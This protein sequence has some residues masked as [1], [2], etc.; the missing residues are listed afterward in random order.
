MPA[1][2][3]E[4]EIPAHA[5]DP[6]LLDALSEAVESGAGLPAVARAA[7][8]LLDASVALIDRSSAVLAVAGAS[9]DQEQK[10]LSGGD[11]VTAVEL[12]VADSAVGELRYR[13]RVAPQPAIARM[14]TTLLALELERSRSPEWESEEVASAFVGDVLER[15]VTDRGDIVARGSELGAD[16]DR[17][18][19]VLVLRA[20][21]RAAQTGEWRERVLTL[22][23][24]ALRSLAPG[25]LATME[26]GSEG[27]AAN[28]AVIVPA[29][30]D[31]RL[32][33]A[34]AGLARELDD[35]LSGFHMTIG[36]SR[37][38]AD[39]VDL[40]RAGNE[41]HLA[42]NVGEAEGRGT[43]AFEDT[44]A[45]RLLLPAMSEDPGELERFY[46][47]TIEPLSKYDDQ[48][49][50]ELVATV[51]AYLDNDG[52]VAATA[53]QLFTHR[54]TVRYRLERVKELCGHDVS[55]TEGREKLGLGLKAM[56]VLGIASPSGP[57]L[58]PG[59]KGGKVA[60]NNED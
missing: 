35:S 34:V 15:R 42:V 51:E 6:G 44:G 54:H 50:T 18:A 38:C 20:A 26:D 55:A 56:R 33:R 14:V 46:A 41:A 39:P 17:G 3:K 47:E 60:R 19:G 22:A 59:T 37:R 9:P 8:R 28:L 24:R 27:A 11:G 5:E 49:E 16:L 31:E 48:Y 57:A 58:E 4:S 7:A 12:R 32:A 45:Y 30:D 36:R 29:E 43:L 21:P 13:A 2:T 25:S 1:S 23:L 52:N 40:Y 10:L 53:K